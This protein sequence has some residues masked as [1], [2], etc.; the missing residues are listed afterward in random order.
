MATY[1]FVLSLLF[2]VAAALVFSRQRSRNRLPLPPGPRRLPFI[3]NLFNRPTDKAFLAFTDMKSQYGDIV[4]L[5]VFGQPF[6]VL[7]S[8]KVANELFE[9]RSANYADRP[10][11]FFPSRSI[12]VSHS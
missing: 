7:N 9:K 5:E 8:A 3:G 10:G 1:H 4:S 6:I 12:Y 2:T 11:M